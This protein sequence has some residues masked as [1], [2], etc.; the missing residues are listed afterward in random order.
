MKLAKR[1]AVIGTILILASLFVGCDF[2]LSVDWLTPPFGYVKTAEG[3]AVKDATVLVYKGT[4]A[5]GNKVQATAATTSATG[6]FSLTAEMPVE[7]V[8][9]TYIVVVSPPTGSTLTFENISVVV[10]ADQYL[11]N[12]GTIKSMDWLTPPFGYVKD[13]DGV[14]VAGASVQVYKGTVADANKI[15]TTAETTAATGY[16]SFDANMPVVN[17][18]TTYVVVVT[19]PAGSSLTFANLSVV[20]PANSYLLNIGTINA[21]GGFYTVSGKVINPR[22][23]ESATTY[24]I[25][26]GGTVEV[27][28]FGST[29]AIK[30]ATIATDGSYSLSGLESGSYIVKVKNA[31]ISSTEW[32]GVP[33]SVEIAGGDVLNKGIFAYTGV[34]ATQ[35]LIILTWDNKGTSTAPYDLDSWTFLGGGVDGPSNVSASYLNDPVFQKA[36]NGRIQAKLERDVTGSLMWASTGAAYPVETT[37]VETVT[38]S[39][40]D[41]SYLRFF[42]HA[43]TGSISGIDVGTVEQ[44]A[45]AVVYVMYGGEHY[46]TFWPSLNTDSTWELFLKMYAD[47]ATVLTIAPA[48][49][50]GLDSPD[51]LTT[52]TS[53]SFGLVNGTAIR[54]EIAQ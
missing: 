12:I 15:Q 16:F 11:W 32:V 48:G 30:T 14:A 29:T 40:N 34:T 43:Y 50:N 41:A 1:I 28:T 4:V 25:P 45:G 33:V 5:D 3:V 46:G 35:A 39:D 22:A 49:W 53:R 52:P 21:Q 26:A 2:T 36:P 17:A 8:E 24:A 38:G 37:L 7:S 13:A 44:P 42:A 6:Y 54:V 47:S 51:N 18:E 9:T 23:L 19:P 27:T 10:P 31:T 20:V